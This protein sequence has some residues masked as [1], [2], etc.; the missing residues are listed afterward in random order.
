VGNTAHLIGWVRQHYDRLE[1]QAVD[2]YSAFPVAQDCAAMQVEL[3]RLPGSD[4]E[5]A[6]LHVKAF[7]ERRVAEGDGIWCLILEKW[8]NAASSRWLWAETKDEIAQKK[9]NKL[10]RLIDKELE[11]VEGFEKVGEAVGELLKSALRGD[12][13]RTDSKILKSG[14]TCLFSEP[15]FVGSFRSSPKDVEV[16]EADPKIEEVGWTIHEIPGYPIKRLTD[17]VRKQLKILGESDQDQEDIDKAKKEYLSAL[18][19][20]T[21]DIDQ[22]ME[23]L[24]VTFFG[25]A[26]GKVTC[27]HSAAYVDTGGS[28]WNLERGVVFEGQ[29]PCWYTTGGFNKKILD[30]FDR[31]DTK[32]NKDAG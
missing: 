24:C 14:S 31:F 20:I 2:V 19:P 22:G 30:Q 27:Y 26:T 11:G 3:L 25:W 29:D 17:A 23:V 18:E 10:V 7:V 16:L 1:I 32:E 4:Y 6:V 12:F 21:G 5:N 15:E 28:L 9:V 13:D 8:K